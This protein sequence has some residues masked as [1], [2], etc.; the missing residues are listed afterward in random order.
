MDKGENMI[1]VSSCLC[2]EKCKY[3]GDDNYHEKVVAYCEDKKVLKVCPEVLGGLQIPRPPAEIVGGTAKDVLD[4]KASVMNCKGKDVTDAFVKGAHKVLS[5][6]KEYQVTE[7]ILKANSPSCGKGMVYDGKFRGKLIKGNG[8]T[9]QC[10]LE[11]GIQVKTEN[12]I[13]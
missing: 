12:E 9:A 8:L 13:E 3:S 10:L 5:L 1:L 7:A 4:G 2:G 11:A 6:A